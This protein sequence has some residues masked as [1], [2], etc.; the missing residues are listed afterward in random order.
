VIQVEG[1]VSTLRVGQKKL[2]ADGHCDTPEVNG[3]APARGPSY[4]HRMRANLQRSTCCGVLR[5]TCQKAV[6]P[7]VVRRVR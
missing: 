1:E 4:C 5:D 3:D 7:L 2:M 6:S